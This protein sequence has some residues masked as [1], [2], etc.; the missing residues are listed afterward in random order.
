LY[1][2]GGALYPDGGALYPDGGA[3]G[4]T[5]WLTIGGALPLGCPYGFAPPY[6]GG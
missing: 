1:P 5:P 3:L 2:D 4:G 6:A